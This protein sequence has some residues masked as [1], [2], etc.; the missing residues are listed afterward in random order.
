MVDYHIHSLYSD[1]KSTY[2]EIISEAQNKGIIEL[3]FSDHLCIH[4]PEW[5]VK[6]D[7]FD[8]L[9]QAFNDIKE[10]EAGNIKIKF[11]LEVD[12]IEDR[13]DEI[14]KLLNRFPLDYT[15]GSVHYVGDWNFDTKENDYGKVDI[16]KFYQNYF[17]ILQ[18]AAKSGLFDIIGHADLVKKFNYYPSFNLNPF[19]KTTAKIFAESGV[20][21]E[22]NTS[23]KNK[24]CREFYPS[25]KF[26]EY[27]FLYNVPVTLGS[28]AH[29]AID[30]AQYFSEAI[31]KLRT[32]GYNQLA[33]FENRQRNFL[34]L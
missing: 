4:Y 8:K 28:D 22:L 32:I 10:I 2:L 13:E 29:L 7:D 23:G 33:I 17:R 27:C 21:I 11:G 16:D 5:A 25:D 30:V 34:W 18:K 14:H 31:L 12:Y 26:L 20:A 9:I 19:Y 15:I 3:G 6:M 24:P 1:G